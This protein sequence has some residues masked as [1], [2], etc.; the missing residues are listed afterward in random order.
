MAIVPHR[1]TR[2]AQNIE[3]WIAGELALADAF[4]AMREERRK[5]LAVTPYEYRL[6]GAL[7]AHL[8]RGLNHTLRRVD[9][10]RHK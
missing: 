7:A 6:C 8:E 5:S 10:L 1:D 3:E 2:Q 4:A 9:G